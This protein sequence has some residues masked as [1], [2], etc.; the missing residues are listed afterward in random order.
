MKEPT[1]RITL[2]GIEVFLAIADEQSISAAARRLGASP[3]AV[4]QQL[5]NL[6]T[7]LGTALLNRN[8]RPM[9]LTPAGELFQRR[10]QIDPERGGAGAGRTGA[11]GPVDADPVPAG[12]DR[13]FRR[14]RDAAPAARHGRRADAAASSCWKPGP[15]TGCSTSLDARAL[16]VIVAADMGAEAD[17]MEVHPILTEPFLAAVPKGAVADGRRCAGGAAAD[18]R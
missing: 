15:A 18:C 13:G 2:W 5:T 12:H 6:E 17:W 10:A 7:A 8:E 9:T 4:S 3:S 11:A 14:R 16:D 1:G